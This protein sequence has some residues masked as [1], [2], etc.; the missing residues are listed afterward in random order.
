MKRIGSLQ[1]PWTPRLTYETFLAAVHE[2]DRDLV[3]RQW[4]AAVRGEPY[5]IEHR[6]VAD[7][8]T[9]WVHERATL[10]WDG[11]GALAG[12]F[13]T[14]HDITERK[15]AEEALHRQQELL[16]VTLT[17]IGDAVL[18][19]DTAGTITFLN[20]VAAALTGRVESDALGKPVSEVLHII[21]ERTRLPAE[22]TVARVLCEGR[23]VALANHTALVAAD[24]REIPIED[25]AAPILTAAGDVAGVV[26]VFHDVTEKRRAQQAL[27][28]SEQRVRLKL[29]S[30]LSP[31]GDIGKLE[32]ADILDVEAI[33]SLLDSHYLLAR[34]PMAI[35]DL[36][37]RVLV[38][39][40]WQDICTKFHRMHPETCRYCIE[41]DTQLSAG[42]L[43]GES[44]LYK[45]KNNMWDIA[46]PIIVGGEH[47]G[48]LFSGQFFFDDEPLDYDLFR[49]QAAQY[50]FDEKQ[51][52]AALDRV[53]RFARRTVEEGMAF[54]TKLAEMLSRL[55][56]SNV[57]LARSLAER[58]ALTGSLRESE[59][60]LREAKDAAEEANRAKGGFLAN[61][62]HEL[63]TPMNAI[64]GMI[65]VALPKAGDATVKDCLE[66]AKGSADL[67]LTLL[68]DLLDSSKIEAGKLELESTPFS[69]RHT[70][71]QVTRVLSVRASEKG[72]CFSWSVADEAPDTLMGDRT[73]LQQI[74]LNLAGNAIKF[75]ERGEVELSVRLAKTGRLG[76]IDRGLETDKQPEAAPSLPLVPDPQSLI[77]ASHPPSPIPSAALE[78]AVR[79]TGIGIAESDM[80]RLFRPFHQADAATTRRFG[81]TGLGLSISSSLVAMMG[82]RIWAESTPGQGSTFRFMVQFPLASQPL[83]EA[84]AR[85]D[86][87]LP[88]ASSL[89]I[90]LVEDNPANQKLASYILRG[91]GPPG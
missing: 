15:R 31:E 86:I 49:A 24:G 68:D 53:P 32:L 38:G 60:R 82:G 27:R 55:S 1:S 56:Y 39:V 25:S 85:I 77:P 81:G 50:G 4:Q 52:I 54:F 28:E 47:V 44:R 33:Q 16:R 89:R 17:S 30:I 7:G 73:R 10:E 74:L 41:S 80:A 66:T 90:L 8:R 46:T 88:A 6:I 3:D 29:Q 51:Y 69:L 84:P 40:G 83:D 26:L 35:I 9:K 37:G 67:L 70:L 11:Q 42:I 76:V 75:T 65:D 18:A 45:C 23:V 36:P 64:L 78:F 63:R 87:S 2:E 22:N 58:D 14:V 5:D 13:G 71:D 72:L 12:A 20:P 57:K 61:I 62:S 59:A 21:D 43:P 79:D 19:C 48:N 34:I 91:R